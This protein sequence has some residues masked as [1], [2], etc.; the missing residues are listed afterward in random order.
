MLPNR[1]RKR[2]YRA[3]YQA[4]TPSHLVWLILIISPR[5]CAQKTHTV[6]SILRR[7]ASFLGNVAC[8]KYLVVFFSDFKKKRFPAQES[9]IRFNPDV[10]TIYV[11]LYKL[12]RKVLGYVPGKPG[13][14]GSCFPRPV[15]LLDDIDGG[16]RWEEPRGHVNFNKDYWEV[17]NAC[18][19][20]NEWAEAE[21]WAERA[22][23]ESMDN[24]QPS[25]TEPKS[26]NY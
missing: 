12:Y 5:F 10:L 23:Q 18:V 7:I 15:I 11:Q 26:D 19:L 8:V 20:A 2:E 25:V 24:Y 14:Q 22:L 9:E 6:G 4:P 3:S 21:L 16:K 17:A 1:S 13:A